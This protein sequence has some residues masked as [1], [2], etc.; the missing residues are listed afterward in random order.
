MLAPGEEGAPFGP[1]TFLVSRDR[2]IWLADGINGRLLVWRSGRPDRIERTV[3]LPLYQ[4][5]SDVA[6]GPRSTYYVLRG[7]PPPNPRTV[8][9]RVSP[10]AQVWQSELAGIFSDQD[11]D[12]AINTALRTGPD[13]RL[14]AVSGKPGSAGGERGWMPVATASGRRIPV[15][16]Q[17]QG[18][19]WPYQPLAG[20][21]RLLST[22][23]SPRADVTPREA[24]VA[25]IDRRGRVV[26]SWRVLSRTDINLNPAT[27]D[28]VGGDPVIV[29]DVTSGAAPRFEWE[30]LVLRL[31]PDGARANFSLSRTIFGDNLL[32][33]VRIGPDGRLYQLGSSPTTGVVVR[34]YS[35]A[36]AG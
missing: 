15:A 8:L 14:Y 31:G 34:R 22:V 1:Q 9:E 6:F 16:A 4:A 5:E 33:D 20:G 32:A 36:P 17:S 23:Y 11:G 19:S 25:V 10:S 30:Y 21:M 35:L 2:S 29:F 27:P 18:D 13:G 24:R 12:L 7:L 3:P 26:R 28:L